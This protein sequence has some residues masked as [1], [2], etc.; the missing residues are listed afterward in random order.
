LIK[1]LN[2]KTKEAEN[3][4]IGTTACTQNTNEQWEI[5]TTHKCTTTELPV[6]KLLLKISHGSLIHISATENVSPD[7]GNYTLTEFY[8]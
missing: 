3:V 6:A 5:I 7:K 8:L 2:A 4:K 1:A